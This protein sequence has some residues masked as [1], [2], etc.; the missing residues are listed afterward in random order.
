M[1]LAR[2]YHLIIKYEFYSELSKKMIPLFNLVISCTY[3]QYSHLHDG[4]GFVI[5]Q[6]HVPM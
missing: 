2:Y 5:V 3:V 6:S 4:M 1:M